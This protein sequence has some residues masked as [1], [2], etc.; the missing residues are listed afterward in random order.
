MWAGSWLAVGAAA[1]LG[2]AY[3]LFAYVRVTHGKESS[4]SR[5]LPRVHAHACRVM[6]SLLLILDLGFYLYNTHKFE[7]LLILNSQSLY[8]ST[9]G[10]PGCVDAGTVWFMLPYTRSNFHYFYYVSTFSV[11]NGGDG[12]Y[13]QS[14]RSSGHNIR[15]NPCP[16]NKVRPKH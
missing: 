8:A 1:F 11:C 13:V 5:N 7:V 15:V 9:W 10:P 12:Q 2:V 14:Q 6:A 16:S 3:G 4:D